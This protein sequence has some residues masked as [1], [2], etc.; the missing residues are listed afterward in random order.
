MKKI[1]TLLFL[2]LTSNIILSQNYEVCQ[3]SPHINTWTIVWGGKPSSN[4]GANFMERQS[5]NV[6]YKE[7]VLYA[8][9]QL[10]IES[11]KSIIK[12]FCK[13]YKIIA[14]YG[15]SRGGVN[16]W[17]QI[18]KVE[19]IGLIDPLIPKNYTLNFDVGKVFMLYNIGVWDRGNRDRLVKV[20]SYLGENN[21]KRLYL[22]H[23]EIPKLFFT[24][25]KR[26]FSKTN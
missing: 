4:Y 19:F 21:S 22:A 2:S 20:S 24:K 12:R 23:L 10:S 7:N 6:F 18:G 25:Y 14:V 5:D 17:E 11:C 8:D 1:I 13:D 9:Y 15:F 16:A 26:G 3:N